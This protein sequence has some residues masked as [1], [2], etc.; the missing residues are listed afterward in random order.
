MDIREEKSIKEKKINT[1][2][3]EK[4]L[5]FICIQRQSNFS[6]FT[7]GR[8]NPV[9]R[10]NEE[11]L[12]AILITKGAKYLV[13]SASDANRVMEEELEDLGFE[14]IKYDWYDQDL[15]GV[16]AKHTKNKKGG[17]D[18]PFPNTVSIQ[19][20]LVTLRSVLTESEVERARILGQ[21]CAEVVTQTA[22]EINPGNTELNVA[23]RIAGYF[24]EEGIFPSVLMVGSDERIYKYRHPVATDKRIRKHILIALVGQKWGLRKS[25][26]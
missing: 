14:L 26:V 10:S 22:Y 24:E 15:A 3:E 9:V 5:E 18:V 2:M 1:L 6:W 11:G 17:L 12:V 7:C 4:G 8:G 25:V 13:S 20:E 23:A 16:I 21:K 19:P